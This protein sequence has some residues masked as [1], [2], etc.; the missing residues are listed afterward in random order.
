MIRRFLIGALVASFLSFGSVVK[1]C[2]NLRIER[3]RNLCVS[4]DN[5]VVQRVVLSPHFN[6]VRFN[7]VRKLALAPQFVVQEVRH[8]QRQVVQKVVVREPL[9]QNLRN[10]VQNLFQS[11]R[12]RN[13]QRVVV[14]QRNIR[15]LRVSH[16]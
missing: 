10:S 4:H 7:V 1:S 14:K 2:D 16:H 3:V 6:T 15:T 11:V 8:V 13:V 9:L 5:F 12:V